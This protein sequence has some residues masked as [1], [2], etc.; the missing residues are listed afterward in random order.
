[1]N[2]A[3]FRLPRKSIGE[4]RAGRRGPPCRVAVLNSEYSGPMAFAKGDRVGCYEILSSLGEGGMGVVY[5][6]RDTRLGRQVALKVLLP[7][8]LTDP[9]RKQ[10]FIQEA[11]SASSLNHP[12]I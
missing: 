11:K 12:N 2:L 8:R 1:M 3:E 6:A 9:L 10:R 5:R 7:E 4:P